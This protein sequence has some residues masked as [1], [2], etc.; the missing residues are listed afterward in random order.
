VL[1]GLLAFTQAVVN[2]MVANEYIPR[3]IMD[4]NQAGNVRFILLG[5][6]L[7]VLVVY[8]PQG[9]FGDKREIALGDR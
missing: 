8:R 3:S 1:W 5:V 2:E 6:M 4:S 7:V 9:M